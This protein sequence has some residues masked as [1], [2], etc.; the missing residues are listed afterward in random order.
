MSGVYCIVECW[1]LLCFCLSL[2]N[3]RRQSANAVVTAEMIS[4]VPLSHRQKIAKV[5][6]F[7]VFE[8][9]IKNKWK[10]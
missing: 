7:S 4:I 8:N 9:K 6:L 1:L 10:K 3:S 5:F 2:S